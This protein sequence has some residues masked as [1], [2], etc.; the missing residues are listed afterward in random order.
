LDERRARLGGGVIFAI[1][2]AADSGS[3]VVLSLPWMKEEQDSVVVSSL[4]LTKEEREVL[5]ADCG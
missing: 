4:P 3:I 1:G 5:A 2:S